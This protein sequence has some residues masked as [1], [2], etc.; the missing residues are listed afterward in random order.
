MTKE[1]RISK[2]ERLT[3]SY[4]GPTIK[5]ISQQ[6]MEKVLSPSSH[7]GTKDNKSGFWYELADSNQNILY[8]KTIS[9]PIQTDIEVFSNESKETIAR[10]KVSESEGIFSLLIPDLPEAKTFSLFGNPIERNEV[11]MQK[12]SAK[13]FEMDLEGAKD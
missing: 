1:S 4:K 7:L 9:N 3:F 12:P 6:K 10:Q 8:Q 11:S 5:L 13:L 2:A